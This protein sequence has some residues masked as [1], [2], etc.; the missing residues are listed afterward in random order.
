MTPQAADRFWARVE[1][2]PACWPW[3]GFRS[4]R[5]YGRF[6]IDGR[7][8]QAHRIAYELVVGPIPDGLQL[9]HLCRNRGCVNPAH[10][11]PV[12]SRENTLRGDTLPAR[13]VT[14]THC[15]AGHPLDSRK[16]DGSRYCLTCN[17]ERDRI[18]RAT[19]AELKRVRHL[20]RNR[21]YRARRDAAL[22]ATSEPT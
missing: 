9:D 11:E 19:D 4:P 17:R 15:P 14:K 6:T 10:L 12:T 20:E 16:A 3:A 13:N 8:H 2:G 22:S 5:G 21:Q 18:Y 1:Q 7:G